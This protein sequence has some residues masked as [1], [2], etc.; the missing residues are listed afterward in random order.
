MVWLAKHKVLRSLAILIAVSNLTYSAATAT[1]VLYAQDVLRVDEGVY[2]VL[3]AAGALGSIAGGLLA[4]KV[5]GA[6]G[7]LRALQSAMAAQVL[8]WLS[9]ALTE[10]PYVAGASLAFAFVGTSIA[11]V[12][13]VSARQ[14]LTPPEMLGRVVT[15]FRLL[16]TGML[17]AGGLVGG[18][19][20]TA[21]GL[22]A[23]LWAAAGILAISTLLAPVLVGRSLASEPREQ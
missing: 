11:T 18:I 5:I 16:G 17:P 8:A 22:H 6:L 3:L 14:R 21:W 10:S 15:S 4:P 7:D 19:A 20:A 9:L 1:L 23:P 13:A 2:G 12:V